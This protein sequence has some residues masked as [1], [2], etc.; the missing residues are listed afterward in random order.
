M[1][2]DEFSK[3]TQD[4]LAKRVG[5][6]C[7]NPM[8]RK[9]TTGPRTESYHIVNIGVGAHITAASPGGPRYDPSLTQEQRQSPDNGIWL[10]Q[11]CAKLVDNDPLRYPTQ[12]LR[13]WKTQ[14]EASA[15]A[16]LEGRAE[17]L[18]TDLSAD[19]DISY[20]RVQIKSERHDYC[21]E[22]KLT[23]LGTEPLGVY[24]VDLEMPSIVVESDESQPHYVQDRSTRK[25][26]F[27]RVASNMGAPEVYPGDTKIVMSIPYYVD[28]EIFWH[29]GDLFQEIVKVTLYRRGFAPFTI[30]RPFEDFQIF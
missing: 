29:R 12:L 11:N 17:P 24:H 26:A 5:V 21:L 3:H 10:C 16:A 28:R 27:F 23:N 30:I 15:L 13:A 20:A 6:R 22:V 1:A 19:L 9:L 25:F 18:P 7:S 4:T 2:R 14:A 8:C